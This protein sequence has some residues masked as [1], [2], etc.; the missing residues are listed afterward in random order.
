MAGRS[1]KKEND[2]FEK[3]KRE[4]TAKKQR[5]KK[6]ENLEI[7]LQ[8]SERFEPEMRPDDKEEVVQSNC[9]KFMAP[10]E[11]SVE[12]EN[13]DKIEKKFVK[14]IIHEPQQDE[15]RDSLEEISKMQMVIFRIG[16]EEYAFEISNIKEIIRIPP[17][18][19]VPNSPFYIAGL[20][21]LRGE[22]LP[23]IDSRRLFGIADVENDEGSRVVVTDIEGNKVGL[24]AD[25]VS[26]V[27]S[28]EESMLKDP[29]ESIRGRDGG[30][31]KG[32]LLLNDG[33]RVIMVLDAVK[34]VNA[35]NYEEGFKQQIVHESTNH[36]LD[37]KHL[38]EEQVILFHIGTEEYAFGIHTVKE[39]IRLADIT[40]VPNAAHYIEGML[41]I[42]NQ[43]LAVIN[44]GM[45]LGKNYKSIDEQ[46][47]IIIIDDG[48]AAFGVIVDRV[49]QVTRVRSD[50]YKSTRLDTKASGME[51]IKGFLEL[52]KGKRLAMVLDPLKLV[53]FEDVNKVLILDNKN[54]FADMPKDKGG[55]ETKL[56]H[57]VIFKL[58]K[59][60]FGISI[61]H[62]KEINRVSEIVHFPGA[63]V[64]ID[65][66][67]NLR[68]DVIPVLNL[69][70]MFKGSLVMSD[71]SKFLVV[72][73]DNKK[74]GI[75]IDSASEVLRIP[76]IHI[77][78]ASEMLKGNENDRYIDAI[79]KLNEGKRIVLILNLSTVLSFM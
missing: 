78:E 50:E 43:L 25:K 57:T 12:E 7:S 68:G 61:H 45:L 2:N 79:A 51:Y 74:I 17:M 60:E 18:K 46:S 69:K 49:S 26:E 53:S 4:M 23:V 72:E 9:D 62:V 75:L 10:V 24:I 59:E 29:P 1:S 35:G 15:N 37:D 33:K 3:M 39:I 32:I 65:G 8:S 5:A 11:N 58:G 20:C 36:D 70:T 38:E 6:Q 64:F 73:Y 54:S 13:G 14:E 27:I 44:L 55:S 16:E 52:N 48:N 40:K 28:I 47:R 31:V 22:L 77:E 30:V 42:R 34:I 63:P 76:K 41:S 66:M 19:N 21:S 71:S 56:E 67:V